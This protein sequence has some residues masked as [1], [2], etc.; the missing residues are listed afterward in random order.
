MPTLTATVTETIKQSLSNFAQDCDFRNHQTISAELVS[1][2][3]EAL[4]S[5]LMDGGKSRLKTLLESYDTTED[6]LLIDTP[7]SETPDRYTYKTTS[8]KKFLT[9]FGEI[10]IN[11]RL[12]YHWKGGAAWIPLD[13]AWNMQKRYAAPEVTE[14][15][16]LSSSMLC[17]SEVSQL[18][19][20]TSPFKPSVSLIHDIIN[21]DGS[22]L[23]D[24]LEQP[25]LEKEARPIELPDQPIT[26]LV[27]S[28]DGANV[29]VREPG[30]KRGRPTER[31]GN[32]KKNTTS[33]TSSCS[34]KNAMIGSFSIYGEPASAIDF[35]TG[36]QSLIANRLQSLYQGQ[37]PEPTAPTFKAEFEQTIQRIEDQLPDGVARILLMDGARNL[38][39]YVENNPLFDD[40]RLVLDYFH[41]SEHLSRLSEAL[42]GKKNPQ[43][44]HW[45]EKWR[46]KIK[47][48]EGGVKAMMRSARRY[49]KVKKRAKSR[50][51]EVE[52]ELSF[53]ERN[54]SK[55]C[56]P[57]L[58]SRGLPIGSGPVESA[59]K[60][61]VKT[62]FC[63]S[64]MRW[65]RSGGQNVMNL[66]VIQKSRQWESCWKT[67]C[68]VG[69]YQSFQPKSTTQIQL[70]AA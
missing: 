7:Q 23:A 38:W 14:V 52:T 57:E 30:K 41:A 5:A 66:R 24:M 28:M 59:C 39:N 64:G 25:A 47:H 9:S 37:M 62:R 49:R 40:Y 34:Y 48:D 17:A 26:A 27:A 68:E 53:F 65:S 43:A 4:H 67:Y 33:K 46:E 22:A 3:T 54:E 36:Q 29:L 18:L 60:M 56:Y 61:I 6:S 50:E 45:Y 12:Y 8:P 58:S 19:A 31:P 35:M 2:F 63:Q 15:L 55:M 20:K 42:F 13:Q 51:K 44:Q 32:E 16:L 1:H 21:Q 10:E 69:G 11:R 70:D